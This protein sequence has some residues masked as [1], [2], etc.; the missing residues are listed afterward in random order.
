MVCDG[1]NHNSS[2]QVP[3]NYGVWEA[4]TQA[5]MS[6]LRISRP[7]VGVVHDAADRRK[8]LEIEFIAKPCLGFVVIVNRVLKILL[9]CGMK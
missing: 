5:P 1:V 9:G 7:S 4:I 2:L 6:A 3:V 8:H